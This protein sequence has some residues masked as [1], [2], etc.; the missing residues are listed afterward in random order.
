MRNQHRPR[1]RAR[2]LTAAL[3]T[4]AVLST[5][6]LATAPAAQAV[7]PAGYTCKGGYQKITA[8]NSGLAV[9]VSQASGNHGSVAQFWWN[10][11]VNQRWRACYITGTDGKRIYRFIGW[12]DRCMAVDQRSLSSGAWVITDHCDDY[13]NA[14]EFLLL[15]V[16]GTNLFA[17]SPQHTQSSGRTWLGAEGNSTAPEAQ[18][19]QSNRAELFSM[20][21]FG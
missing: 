11:F 21:Q 20:E 5:T 16:P 17:L 19:V 15:E 2:L 7:V 8:A 6:L 12:R 14:Q 18:I 1:S 3:G 13:N 9:E 4:T 10:D